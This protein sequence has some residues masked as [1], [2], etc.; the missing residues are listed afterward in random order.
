MRKAW[1]ATL[2]VSCSGL[3][4]FFL[5][6]SGQPVAGAPGP[7]TGRVLFE[8]HCAACH[9]NGGNTINPLKTL[10]GQA[11]KA[12]GITK[13]RDIIAKMRHPGPGMIPFDK[14][15]LSDQDAQSIADYIL[16]AFK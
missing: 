15:T 4:A 9:P 16:E 14:G 5:G 8:R 3:V 2:F 6:L 13:A 1:K 10:H 11:L 12:N 7:E